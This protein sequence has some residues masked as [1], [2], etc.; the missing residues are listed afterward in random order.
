VRNRDVSPAA[1]MDGFTAF[2]NETRP[3]PG[4]ACASRCALTFVTRCHCA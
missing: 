2:R 4:S 3:H 1:S